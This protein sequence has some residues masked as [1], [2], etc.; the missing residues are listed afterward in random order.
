MKKKLTTKLLHCKI[1]ASTASEWLAKP[2]NLNTVRKHKLLYSV[3]FVTLI[4]SAF[5]PVKKVKRQPALKEAFAGRFYVGTAMNAGQIMERDS[6]SVRVIKENFNAIVAENCMKSGPIQ[7]LEGEFNFEQPD[8]FVEFGEK[9]NLFIT[10][11]CLVWHSQAPSWF[12][13][14]SQGK[15]VTREVLIERMKKHIYTVAG[16]YKGRVK[17][18]DVVNE[19][20]NE[21]GTLRMTK[22][23]EIIG[24]DYLQLAY[25]FAHDADPSAELY[26]N[27]Y[28]LANPAKRNGAIALVKKLKEQGARV[29][30]IGEQCHIGLNYPDIREFEKS[31]EAFAALG[32]KV[33]ITEMDISVLP[34]PDRRMSAD[35][36]AS[37]DYQKKLNPFTEGLPDSVNAIFEKRYLDFFKLFLKH[38]KVI[39]RVTL[40]GVNDALSWKNNFPV[41]GRTDYPLLFDRKNQPKPVVQKIMDLAVKK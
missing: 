36:S 37:F 13:K 19:A 12:F 38:K 26:Y 29:D 40:W 41:R 21:D 39:T 17:G 11:H 25:Q 9:N 5:S 2:L 33:M 18:W 3:L 20:L 31:I 8:K 24:E 27:D 30:A 22:F 16:R 32:V 10:G 6:A 23:L 1:I 28:A 14:D 4:V 7:P 34:S 15:D 35:I